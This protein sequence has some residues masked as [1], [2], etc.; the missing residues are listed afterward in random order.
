MTFIHSVVYE[1]LPGFTNIA[2]ELIEGITIN[3]VALQNF[4]KYLAILHNASSELSATEIDDF[5]TKVT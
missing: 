3:K 1:E 4:A 2:L 5:E